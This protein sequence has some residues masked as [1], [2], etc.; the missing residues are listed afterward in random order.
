M[1]SNNENY[2]TTCYPMV[3]HKNYLSTT[4]SSWIIK[5]NLCYHDVDIDDDDDEMMTWCQ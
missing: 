1:N 5:K 3:N 4:H 2:F